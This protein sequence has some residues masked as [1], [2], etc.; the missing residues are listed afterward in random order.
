MEN[1]KKEDSKEDKKEDWDDC[2]GRRLG[3]AFLM[4][5][6]ILISG[7]TVSEMRPQWILFFAF[8]SIPAVFTGF[9][10]KAWRNRNAPFV[11]FRTDI[12]LRRLVYGL[13][14][15]TY[16]GWWSVHLVDKIL[17]QPSHPIRIEMPSKF[18]VNLTTP[19]YAPIK[20]DAQHTYTGNRTY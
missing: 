19:S 10:E 1:K 14:V 16:V 6:G 12:D 20:I 2:R 3:L 17:N 9:I 13:I 8:A 11:R 18:D 4:F 7:L 15:I 5:F